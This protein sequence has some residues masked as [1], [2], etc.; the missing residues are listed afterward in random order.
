MDT[1]GKPMIAHSEFLS[2]YLRVTGHPYNVIGREIQSTGSV[3]DY[4]RIIETDPK[5]GAERKGSF[6]KTYKAREAQLE[7]NAMLR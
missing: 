1:K 7:I 5:T 3:I 4:V 6:K 2:V